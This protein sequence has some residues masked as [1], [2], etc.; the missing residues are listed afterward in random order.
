MRITILGLGRMGSA[1]A[2]N[3]LQVG[4]QVTIYNRSPHR[5]AA[6]AGTGAQPAHSV[7]EAVA[8][9]QVALTMVADDAAEE[10][11]SFGPGGILAHLPAG[12]IHLCM[13]SIGVATSRQLAEAHA[14]AGQGYVAAPVLR[15]P[16]AAAS[17][18]LWILAGGPE[19]QVNHCM[20]V[21]EALGRSVTRVGPR[22]ELAHALRL[23]ATA[24]T[25]AMVEALS[26]VLIYGETLGY[27]PADYLRLL[28]TGLFGSPL[29]DAFGGMI[30]RHDY[31][32]ANQPLD[33][34]A[35]DLGLAL[36]TAGEA[37]VPMPVATQVLDLLE[38]A[39][40]AGLGAMDLTVLS[41]IRREQAVRAAEAGPGPAEA[42]AEPEPVSGPEPEPRPEPEPEVEP[43]PS[44]VAAPN[45]RIVDLMIARADSPKIELAIEPVAVAAPEP[46]AVAVAGP[47]PDPVAD[48][49]T[50]PPAGASP[51]PPAEPG[52]P[53]PAPEPEPA[54]QD[55]AISEL[56][57]ASH[58]E[59]HERA[60][61][62]WLEGRRHRTP[63]NSF[64]EVELA[65]PHVILVKVQR[66]LLLN[67]WAV[68]DL[69]PL[70][71][72]RARVRMPGD[73]EL[74]VGRQAAKDIRHLLGA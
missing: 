25:A 53:G 65:L 13:S 70:F 39:R 44:G 52:Q 17:R 71:G 26:E 21:L 69:K 59:E 6:M 24:L 7:A 43:P 62:A 56:I 33:L 48:P 4:H 36:R 45:G 32:P 38:A 27:P 66:N 12:A 29:M 1:M 40:T 5:L 14:G 28:N 41:L 37:R 30:V 42:E 50:A 55:L 11:L 47:A 64:T 23:G 16:G 3:L 57:Q 73:I 35:K 9:A 60:I 63:W 51:E 46:E 19:V 15:G 22:A 8:N 68:E 18:Q 20:V 2:R 74:T 72:G 58:F 54:E 61:W 34:A 31:E 10:Q 67:P 49:G